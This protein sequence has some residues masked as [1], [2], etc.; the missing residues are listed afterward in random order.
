MTNNKAPSNQEV[1]DF[2]NA[3][4]KQGTD[5]DILAAALLYKINALRSDP[6]WTNYLYA[7]VRH[8]QQNGLD[9]LALGNLNFQS[10]QI[11]KIIA[12]KKT[13]TVFPTAPGL[14]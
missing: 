14:H 9:I 3:I 8:F 2:F 1:N 12:I 10:G 4:I 5:G 7:L 11:V 13:S 6:N